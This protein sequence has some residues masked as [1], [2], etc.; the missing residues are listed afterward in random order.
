MTS[1]KHHDNGDAAAVAAEQPSIPAL[2]PLDEHNQRL[3]AN[4]H[5]PHW[6][7]PT[8]EGRYNLVVIGAGTAGLVSAAGAA[9]L[10]AKVAL[11]ERDLMGGDCLNVGCVPS[12]ALI[13]CGRAAAEARR[14]EEFGVEIPGQP[15][16]DFGTVME[17]MRRLRAQ[18]SPNDSVQRFSDLGVDV[19]LGNA[20]FTGPDT[21]EVGGLK[22]K[23]ARAAIATGARATPLPI[24]GIE[25]V[26]YL[27]NETVFS[28]TE[29][30]ERLAV[31]GAGPIGSEMA[32]TF[33]R[34]GSQVTL[35]ES[36]KQVL[37]REDA[38]AAEIVTEAMRRDGVHLVCGGRTLEVSRDGQ[39]KVLKFECEGRRHEMR[40]D[41]ILLGV[42]RKPNVDGLGLEAA[43]VD[44]DPRLG[45]TVN[46]KLRTSNRRVFAAGD[47]CSRFKFTHAADAMA[48]IVLQ[49]A[50]FFGRARASALTIP[51]C[52]YTEPEIAHVGLYPHEAEAKGIAV[53]TF[54]V[55]MS[56]VDR[57]I[58]D[59]ETEGFVKIHLKRKTDQIIGATIVAAHAGDLIA[60]L[61]Q[62]MTTG[63]GLGKLSKTI[64]PYPT[65]AEAIKKTADA[66]NR[67]R[68]TPFVKK[69]FKTLLAWR[70]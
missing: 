64:F 55:E 36:E 25:E 49:N 62:A 7:N 4:G 26:G 40:V 45:V 61:S 43:G 65:Q 20:A 14:A 22:L 11:I 34:L 8:P 69:L 41:Q 59:G 30:P 15:S 33:A 70:R 5:P 21:V 58:L 50:L 37:P 32:Q 1:V 23:F 39:E 16:V 18:I 44:Y 63:I 60:Q 13:R 57:A 29:L 19:Y 28:L 9:G 46:D 3:E 38:D 24:E 51:W 56:D 2:R 10:G 53:D 27:T 42:G 67:T 31:I 35:I 47:V 54:K 17:R 66:F 48:R 6:R 12:K 68:L 52:T